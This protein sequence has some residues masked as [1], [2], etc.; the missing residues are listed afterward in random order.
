MAQEENKDT[1]NFEKT[2]VIDAISKDDHKNINFLINHRFSVNE[3]S[4]DGTTPLT[5]AILHKNLNI[6]HLLI[7][8]GADPNMTYPVENED[9]TLVLMSPLIKALQ[10]GDTYC[11]YRWQLKVIYKSFC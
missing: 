7:E 5:A 6:V 9:G 1:D 3:P 8:K 10:L 4:N 11:K 2:L